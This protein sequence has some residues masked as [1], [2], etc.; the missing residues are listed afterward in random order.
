VESRR[1]IARAR[2]STFLDTPAVRAH[3]ARGLSKG[4]LL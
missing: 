3:P 4:T 1:K 2:D